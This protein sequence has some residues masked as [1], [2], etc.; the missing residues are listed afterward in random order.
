MDFSRT[1]ARVVLHTLL[2]TVIL[3]T[4]AATASDEIL[5]GKLEKKSD[6][7]E[8]AIKGD[9]ARLEKQ[10]ASSPKNYRVMFDLANV[11]AEAKNEEK[12][13]DMFLK[14]IATNP[15]YVEAMVNLGGLYSDLD[16][17]DE[18]ITWFEKALTLDPENCKARSNLGNA[19]Y[20]KLRYPDAMFEYRR[21]VEK[22]PNCVSAM[23]NIAVAFADAGLFRD[24]VV[25]WKKVVQLAPGS[26]AARSAQEN[27]VIL[28][29]FTQTPVPAGTKVAPTAA[30]PKTP[31]KTSS[32]A[33][34]KHK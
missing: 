28:D 33:P 7:S 32:K 18:A 26:D 2:C 30:D 19:Y 25:Y 13:K 24:A 29:R 1:S 10:L 12:A 9:I 6:R 23:Y 27:I 8:A 14:A 22:D 5:G 34:Q 4:A 3:G 31:Q 15:K 11:Y 16:Q 20:A 17:Q 21:A